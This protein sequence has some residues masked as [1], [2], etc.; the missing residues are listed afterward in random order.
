MFRDSRVAGQ[1]IAKATDERRVDFLLLLT[2]C[3]QNVSDQQLTTL[4]AEQLKFAKTRHFGA[5]KGPAFVN[6]VTELTR[7]VL[8]QGQR[9]DALLFDEAHPTMAY[10]DILADALVARIAPWI[11]SR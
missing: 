8:Q 3:R 2:G 4:Q 6:G 11:E 9:V 1:R 7:L 10:S 5:K